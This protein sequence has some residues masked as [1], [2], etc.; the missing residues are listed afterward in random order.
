[1]LIVYGKKYNVAK[2]I[3][4]YYSWQNMKKRCWG[5]TS[6]ETDNI[7]YVRKGLGYS[8]NWI[9]YFGFLKD[10]GVKPEKAT[11][12]RIDNSLGYTKANCK[13][14]TPK[15]QANNKDNTIKIRCCG[16]IYTISDIVS[17][18]KLSRTFVFKH[19]TSSYFKCGVVV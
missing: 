12:E 9:S 7:N 19:V 13:W 11:L 4:G 14:A 10:M 16:N 8:S 2:D 15:E 3:P 5:M 1:M 18:C 17:V 6:T